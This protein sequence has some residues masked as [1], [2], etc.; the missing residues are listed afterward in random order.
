MLA[1]C[2]TYLSWARGC[3]QYWPTT[4]TR[5]VAVA[6]MSHSPPA[7]KKGTLKLIKE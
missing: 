2:G 4:G 3:Y 5:A 7:G 6:A 1:Q